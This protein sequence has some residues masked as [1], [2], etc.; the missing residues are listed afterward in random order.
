MDKLCRLMP[1]DLPQLIEPLRLAKAGERMSGQFSLAEMQRL[2]TLLTDD[3]GELVFRLDFS[4]D[5]NGIY[6]ITGEITATMQV[7]CQR[8]L[9]PLLLDVSHH[10]SLGIVRNSEGAKQLL[11]GYEPLMLVEE[12]VTLVEL[13][14]DEL[15]LALPFSPTHVPGD[16]PGSDILDKM[17]QDYKQN[18]FA[19]LAK[20]KQPK[21]T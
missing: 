9:E 5:T 16:C 13:V 12:T 10:V 7:L 11:S 3:R 2:Q 18:P 19:G 4:V 14:E 17:E 21:H 20:L 15:I 1:P 6:C 8:C